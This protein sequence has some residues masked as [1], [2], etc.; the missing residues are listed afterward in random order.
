MCYALLSNKNTE[1][2]GKLEF[3]VF[4]DLKNCAYLLFSISNKD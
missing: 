3:I 2:L 1:H 4:T